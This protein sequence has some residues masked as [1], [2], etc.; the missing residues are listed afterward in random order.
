MDQEYEWDCRTWTEEEA[1]FIQD[2]VE[3]IGNESNDITPIV[4]E[5]GKNSIDTPPKVMELELL[6]LQ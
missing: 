5:K 6:E 3:F 4:E 1:D 2:N